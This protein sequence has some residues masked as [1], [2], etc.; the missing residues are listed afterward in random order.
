MCA[1]GVPMGSSTEF[2]GSGTAGAPD[3]DHIVG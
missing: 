1:R 2:S 3:P